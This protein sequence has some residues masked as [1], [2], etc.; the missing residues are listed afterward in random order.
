MPVE[1]W[2]AVGGATGRDAVATS[3]I[4]ELVVMLPP[5][6]VAAVFDGGGTC[7]L[8]SS[9]A[10]AS[11]AAASLVAPSEAEV[12]DGGE[13][14]GRWLLEIGEVVMGM[15]EDGGEGCTSPLV[16]DE[17]AA[18]A[19]GVSSPPVG[20]PLPAAGADLLVADDVVAEAPS[21]SGC[22]SLEPSIQSFAWRRI[23]RG[24]IAW[25]GSKT[26]IL[27]AILRKGM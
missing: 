12:E 26:V 3:A 25:S 22:E 7:M 18:S 8:V 20:A 5:T 10:A 1:N 16:E 4:E 24:A 14:K 6:A 23:A 9:T 11:L 27:V 15:E 19:A 2:A 21:C 13:P 17:V